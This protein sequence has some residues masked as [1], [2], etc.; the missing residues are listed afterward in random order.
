MKLGPFEFLEKAIFSVEKQI[1]FF[2]IKE[3]SWWKWDHRLNLILHLGYGA[4][5]P[6]ALS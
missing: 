3:G 4:C 2:F 6:T 5:D 1:F